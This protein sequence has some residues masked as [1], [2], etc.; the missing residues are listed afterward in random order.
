L[1]DQLGTTN[2]TAGE[3]TVAT[4]I[5]TPAVIN[6]AIATALLKANRSS[7][8][9]RPELVQQLA[10][11]M[12]TREFS[13]TQPLIFDSVGSLLDGFHRWSAVIESGVAIEFWLEFGW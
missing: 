8:R 4:V 9:I 5:A 1:T 12:K 10:A 13:A 11:L 7:K 2:A 3:K 6:P